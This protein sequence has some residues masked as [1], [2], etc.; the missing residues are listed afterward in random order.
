VRN[1]VHEV[2][3]EPVQCLTWYKKQEYWYQMC[4]NKFQVSWYHSVQSG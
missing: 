4:F 3:G 1:S 2:G